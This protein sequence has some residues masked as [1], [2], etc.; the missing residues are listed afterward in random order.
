MMTLREAWVKNPRGVAI[1]CLLVILAGLFFLTLPA[2]AV[3]TISSPSSI[4]SSNVTFAIAG[5]SGE[6]YVGYGEYPNGE[7]WKSENFTSPTS[8]TA[9]GSPILGGTKYY[10]KACDQTGCGNEVS[11]TMAAITP[12]PTY[13]FDAGMNSIISSHFNLAYMG[14]YVVAAY[15]NSNPALGGF[16]PSVFVGF[17]MGCI[18]VG[19]WRKTKSTRL[20]SILLMILGP[21]IMYPNVGLYLG[22]PAVMQSLG[23]ILFAL[24]F[25]GVMLSFVKK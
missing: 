15:V 4:T 20:I 9:W 11:Y 14:G 23:A 7:T 17:I 1:G 12:L 10:A 22:M 16:P 19:F 3:P 13:H 21:L 2:S 18:I 24:G 6:T 25:A 5:A 8:I